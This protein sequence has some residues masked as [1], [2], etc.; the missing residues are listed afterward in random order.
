MTTPS[1]ST[2]S[3]AAPPPPVAS[4][5]EILARAEAV[6]AANDAVQLA[7]SGGPISPWVLGAYFAHDG[8]DLYLFVEQRGK[9]AANLR[10]SD[11]VAFV[12]SEND[13]MK[14]FVQGHGRAVMLDADQADEVRARLLA[15][16]PWFQTY[17]PVMPVRLEPTELYVS[18]LAAGW[19]PAKVWR[20]T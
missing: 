4:P 9:T 20:R 13:A 7:T 14:D 17:T 16:M 18:S 12:V 1:T 10:A 6:F 5:A 15:K 2:P 19:F 11:R 3:P 8:A